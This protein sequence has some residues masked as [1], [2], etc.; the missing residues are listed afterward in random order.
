MEGLWLVS[1][2]ALWLLAMVGALLIVGI[3]R[4]IGIMNL[5][6]ETLT[7]EPTEEGIAIG[8]IIPDLRKL[9]DER[10]VCLSTYS[11]C[12]KSSRN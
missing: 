6:L 1:Y 11:S 7:H 8:E 10:G 4:Q 3:L 12:P 5:K 2:L 9:L